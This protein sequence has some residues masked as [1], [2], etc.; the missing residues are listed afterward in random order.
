MKNPNALISMAHVSENQGNPY[1]AFC[2]Y[3]KFCLFS[4]A[5]DKMNIAEIKSAVVNEF[6]IKIPNN[7]IL[8]CLEM[9]EA[10]GFASN[11]RHYTTRKGNYDTNEFE[12]VRFAFRRMEE[13]LLNSLIEY[14]KQYDKFWEPEYARELLIKTLYGNGFAYEVFFNNGELEPEK[15]EDLLEEGDLADEI[16]VDLDSVS[17]EQSLSKEPLFADRTYVGK[18]VDELLKGDSIIKDYLIK[19]C[20]GLM[21]CIGTYQLP[22]ENADSSKIQIKGTVFYFDTRLLLRLLGCAGKAAVEATRELVAMIQSNGGLIRY[23]PHTLKEMEFAFDEA[24]KSCSGGEIPTD[25]EMRIYVASIGHSATVLSAKKANLVN[26][27]SKI[28]ILEQPLQN[29]SEKERVRYGFD[30]NDFVQYMQSKL[31]WDMQVI[32]NDAMSIW[33]AHMCR[34]GN[35]KEYCGTNERLG[36][37][38]TNNPMLVKISTEYRESHPNTTGIGAWKSNR[39]PVITDVRLTCRLWSPASEGKNVPLLYLSA[40]AVAAQRPTKQYLNR[41]RELAS[42][43]GEHVP[44]FSRIPLPAYFD[45]NVADSLFKASKGKSNLDIGMFVTTIEELREVGLKEKEEENKQIQEQLDVVSDKLDVQTKNIINGAIDSYSNKL[46]LST[47]AL[48]LV[49]KLEIPIGMLFAV[50]NTIVSAVTGEWNLM[51][52]SLIVVI[53]LVVEYLFASDWVKNYILKKSLPKLEKHFK[54]SIANRLSKAEKVYE[55]EILNAIVD[56]NKLIKRC[57]ELIENCS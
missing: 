20:E 13:E 51:W 50:V 31:K 54:N 46:T 35:Y 3:I 5:N 37:F 48:W 41:I 43:I 52:I 22:K 21:I 10:E 24:T 6:G 11:K 55:V 14:V 4:N 45:D 17:D 18:F 40:N 8:R 33:E 9:I 26:E 25:N 49:L 2:E 7:I 15:I 39:L 12:K 38:V 34:R 32:E 44:E 53:L 27:L 56:Q 47:I 29:H 23:F 30:Y 36:V 42:K 57:K 19:I 28:N 16:L 1:S